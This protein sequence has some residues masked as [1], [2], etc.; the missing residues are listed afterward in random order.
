MAKQPAW[1]ISLRL[2][3]PRNALGRGGLWSLTG[4]DT[5]REM[6]GNS[7]SYSAGCCRLSRWRKAQHNGN[8]TNPH[9]PEM[10]PER[11]THSGRWGKFSAVTE[12]GISKCP[13]LLWK[14]NQGARQKV[15]LLRLLK[16]KSLQEGLLSTARFLDSIFFHLHLLYQPLA[17]KR[18]QADLLLQIFRLPEETAPPDS[19]VCA[20]VSHLALASGHCFESGWSSQSER[21]D[22]SS[23]ISFTGFIK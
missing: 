15:M 19:A 1:S 5:Q 10:T 7:S 6:P 17:G 20:P 22:S 14:K 12:R 18:S 8:T 23:R 3:L 21:Q 13:G 16:D 2:L 4:W 11:V 9:Q